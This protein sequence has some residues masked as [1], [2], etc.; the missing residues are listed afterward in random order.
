MFARAWTKV[1]IILFALFAA[2]GAASA[3]CAMN[4]AQPTVTIC[5]PAK[6]STVANPV[7]FVGLTNS[8]TT[9]KSMDV[10]VDNVVVYSV[11]ANKV[12]TTMALTPGARHILIRGKNTAG[13]TFWKSEDISVTG[14]APPPPDCTLNTTQPSVTICS[15]A[16]SSTVADRCISWLTRTQRRPSPRW[17]FSWTT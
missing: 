13:T 7:H 8:A 5:S 1:A 11:A 16:K 12:D 4:P 17:I 9:V 6:S 14:A 15:P 3:Q 10:L 2:N